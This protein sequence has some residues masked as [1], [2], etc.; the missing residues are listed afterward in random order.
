[1]RKKLQCFLPLL[2][3][4]PFSHWAS[5][6]KYQFKDKIIQF[7]CGS[8]RT[9]NLGVGG[10]LEWLLGLNVLLWPWSTF[11]NSYTSDT[12]DSYTSQP[13]KELEMQYLDAVSKMTEWSLFDSKASH[14]WIITVLQVCAPTSN[15]EEVEV[16]YF[17]EHLQEILELTPT[18]DVLFIIGD[19]N[20]KVGSQEI[21][22][23]I[24]KFG[25][26]YRMKQGKG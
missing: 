14:S 21:P 24:G 18:K 19:W 1:M 25:L 23:V 22:G 3:H 16:E 10:S 20:A 15:A 8:W 26:G 9:L 11:I 7:Q 12:S 17:Y 4:T 6:S 2:I 5:L 13:T